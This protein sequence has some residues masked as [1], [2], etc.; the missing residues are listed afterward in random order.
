MALSQNAYSTELGIDPSL[1]MAV[2]VMHD[3]ELGVGKA[4][5]MHTLRLLQVEDMIEEFDA[6]S[7]PKIR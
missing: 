3:V 1:L 6:R 5:A 7:V 4:L 2:D